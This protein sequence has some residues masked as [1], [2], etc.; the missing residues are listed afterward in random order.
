VYPL[1]LLLNRDEY[2]DRET[3]AAGWWWEDEEIIGGKDE[4]GGGTWMACSKTK[5]RLSFL[6]NFLELNPSSQ[7]YT[8]GVLPLRFLQSNKEP[9]EFA[10]ELAR[11]GHLYN[12]FNLMIATTTTMLYLTNRPNSGES[13]SFSIEEVPPGIHVLSNSNFHSPWPKA[14]HLKLEFKELLTKYVG[15]GSDD[16]HI[17][18]KEFVT[19]LMRNTVKVNDETKLPHI[20]SPDWEFSLSSIFVNVDTPLG[21]YGT[22][23]TSGVTI[24]QNGE[25]MFYETYLERDKTWKEQTINFQMKNNIVYN[26]YY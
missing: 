10:Q 23:S 2:H 26:A 5:A 1:I 15:K 8:R 6:T 4:V 3:K 25:T 9:K 21:W 22:R 16:H 19:R 18:I 17:P 13:A 14:Q 20:C 11:E 12:G 7:A 24:R